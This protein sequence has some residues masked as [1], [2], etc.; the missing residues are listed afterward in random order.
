[1]FENRRVHY[2]HSVFEVL[3]GPRV[4]GRRRCLRVR[5]HSH[6]RRPRIDVSIAQVAAEIADQNSA[7]PAHGPAES[8]ADSTHS[9]PSAERIA[10]VQ[11]SRP[12]TRLR[13]LPLLPTI[14][15][16]QPRVQRE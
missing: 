9:Q 13:S 11:H 14:E 6:A 4:T 1:M 15:L 10:L 16:E 12:A 5:V 3:K 7:L 8:V 2:R